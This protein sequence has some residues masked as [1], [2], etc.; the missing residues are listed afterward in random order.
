MIEK[1]DLPEIVQAYKNIEEFCESN[2]LIIFKNPDSES[3]YKIGIS[4]GSD[5]N[6][7]FNKYI[8]GKG[9]EEYKKMKYN[10]K[11]V[12]KAVE[13]ISKDYNLEFLIG[14]GLSDKGMPMMQIGLRKIIKH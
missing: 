10:I 1:E 11:K 7:L 8:N 14:A 4:L 13:K 12:K 2:D 3:I 6:E 9:K 5:F